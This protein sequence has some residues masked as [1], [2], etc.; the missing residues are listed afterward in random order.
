M[1]SSDI[2]AVTEWRLVKELSAPSGCK[3][4]KIWQH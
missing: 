3:V 2:K 1:Q 4:V